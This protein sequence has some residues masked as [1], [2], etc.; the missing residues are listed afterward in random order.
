MNIICD[1][2]FTFFMMNTYVKYYNLKMLMYH[3]KIE[4]LQKKA[5]I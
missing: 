3:R 5:N 2:T 4:I 1:D